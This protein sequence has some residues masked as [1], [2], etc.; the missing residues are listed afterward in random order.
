MASVPRAVAREQ[1]RPAVDRVLAVAAPI[2]LIRQAVNMGE[3]Q[4]V[5]ASVGDRGAWPREGRPGNGTL[6]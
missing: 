5:L 6:V 3:L 2:G 1:V 4:A